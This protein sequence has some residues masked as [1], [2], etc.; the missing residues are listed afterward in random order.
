MKIFDN[1]T[2][3]EVSKS[4]KLIL[5]IKPIISYI[6][7]LIFAIIT[8]ISL[9]VTF[10]SNYQTKLSCEK[11]PI[12]NSAVIG[13]E[14]VKSSW[15]GVKRSYTN[16]SS[17]FYLAELEEKYNE[18]LK[19]PDYEVILVTD[20]NKILIAHHPG[21]YHY[22]YWKRR[23]EK[24]N[25]FIDSQEDLKLIVEESNKSLVHD[26]LP[27]DMFFVLIT[28]I[29]WLSKVE[30]IYNL[31]LE[32][33][34]LLIERKRIFN[35]QLKEIAFEDIEKA[36]LEKSNNID[37]S[38]DRITFKML[39]GELIPLTPYY[40]SNLGKGKIIKKINVYL[41]NYYKQNKI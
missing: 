28:L 10:D 29:I 15:I 4:K 31:S 11:T 38:T 16:I 30:V 39:S 12:E 13:C 25:S 5:K 8:L 19:I 7:F 34:K 21:S 22:D 14:L 23:I 9:I 40:D 36:F 32:T 2:I 6:F 27:I 37:T 3:T 18:Y 17:T 35:K 20:K 26:L 1:I 33:G 41:K 24:I